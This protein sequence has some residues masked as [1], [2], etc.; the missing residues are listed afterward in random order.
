GRSQLLASFPVT[1]ETNV[2][3]SWAW[4][5]EAKHRPMRPATSS[6][7][8]ILVIEPSYRGQSAPQSRRVLQR[9]LYSRSL[10]ELSDV[11]PGRPAQAPARGAGQSGGHEL[12][13]SSYVARRVSGGL[14]RCAAGFGT[15]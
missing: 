14:A 9:C 11:S 6:E 4:A 8:A 7:D 3:A 5:G 10:E 15:D 1:A 12:R 13:M 2:R